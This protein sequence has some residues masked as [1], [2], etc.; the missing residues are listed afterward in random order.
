MNT[1]RIALFD[2][3]TGKEIV[4]F[5]GLSVVDFGPNSG[6]GQEMIGTIRESIRVTNQAKRENAES[7]HHFG[8][9]VADACGPNLDYERA[10]AKANAKPEEEE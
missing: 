6:F 1:Y 7:G 8:R 5:K 2:E 4:D 3:A 9:V 10:K